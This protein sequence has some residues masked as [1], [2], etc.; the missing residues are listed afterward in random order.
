MVAFDMAMSPMIACGTVAGL[1][2]A[3]L[4]YMIEYNAP[5][6]ETAE[7]TLKQTSFLRAPGWLTR[8][9][10]EPEAQQAQTVRTV[11]GQATAPRGRGMGDGGRGAN[12]PSTTSGYNWGRGHRLGDS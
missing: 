2:V 7:P 6:H 3:H 11:Y 1:L 10:V 8:L 5:V 12:V 9:L 4:L